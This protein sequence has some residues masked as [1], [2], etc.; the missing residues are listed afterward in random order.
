MKII[1]YNFE[2]LFVYS[3]FLSRITETM[4]KQINLFLLV[5]LTGTLFAQDNLFFQAKVLFDE[6]QYSAS[7]S[8]LNQIEPFDHHISVQLIA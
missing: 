3:L 8:V 4:K 5:F 1:K 7:Q 2:A 6:G